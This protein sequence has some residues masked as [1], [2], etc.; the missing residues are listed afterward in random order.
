[1]FAIDEIEGNLAS[2]G[3]STPLNTECVKA[4]PTLVMDT[5][6][7][8]SDFPARLLESIDDV[9]AQTDGVLFHSE[10]FQGLSLMQTRHRE[11]VKCIY[12]DPPYNTDASAIDYKNGY[13]A[14]SWMSL[15]NDRLSLSKPIMTPDGVLIA[16]IDDEQQ[17][18]LSFLL[19]DG[20]SPLCFRIFAFKSSG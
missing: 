3:Y 19:S 6:H 17:R 16:A 7:F 15:L 13:K 1:M 18:E 10:N 2:P 8:T 12:I 11:R 5:R 9:D 14:S 20:S 4:H